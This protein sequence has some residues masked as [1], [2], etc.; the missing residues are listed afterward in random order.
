MI[1]NI[2]T[3]HPINIK[4]PHDGLPEIKAILAKFTK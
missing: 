3:C 2:L 4:M 1:I